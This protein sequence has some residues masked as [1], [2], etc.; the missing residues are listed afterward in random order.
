MDVKL[1]AELRKKTLLHDG[2]IA[3]YRRHEKSRKKGRQWAQVEA[4]CPWLSFNYFQLA[5]SKISATCAG[6]EHIVSLG[7][8]HACRTCAGGRRGGRSAATM[9]SQV[10]PGSKYLPEALLLAGQEID[11]LPPE[12]PLLGALL[13]EA[14]EI[15]A[16]PAIAGVTLAG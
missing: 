6:W 12:L 9:G 16:R 8:V 2:G 4:S 14:D 15:D 13:P 1:V 7:A 10:R 11:L 3:T 5:A